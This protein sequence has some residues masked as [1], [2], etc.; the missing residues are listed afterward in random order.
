MV[1]VPVDAPVDK[2]ITSHGQGGF[3]GCSATLD[4]V[5]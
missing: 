1:I 2:L 4:A 5:L 3:S